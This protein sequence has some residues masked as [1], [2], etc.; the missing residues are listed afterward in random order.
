MF[1]IGDKVTHDWYPE[2]GVGVI[3]KSYL[4]PGTVRVRWT[5]YKNG[6]LDAHM[7]GYLKLISSRLSE[8]QIANLKEDV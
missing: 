2:R 8:E 1:R 4:E 6:Y 5:Y 3:E 7:T